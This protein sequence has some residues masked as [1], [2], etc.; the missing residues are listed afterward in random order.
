ML[1]TLGAH[2]RTHVIAYLALF[3]A[4]AGTAGAVPNPAMHEGDPAGGDLTGTYPD[5][6]IAAGAVTSAKIADGA[7]TTG[8]LANG[9][10]STAKIADGAVT[11]AKFGA[12]PTVR[13]SRCCDLSE[14]P[15]DGTP[16]VLAFDAEDF[17]VGG[18][19]TTSTNTSRL[20]ASVD[21]V[22]QVSANVSWPH[23][24]GIGAGIREITLIVNGLG[25]QARAFDDQPASG[26]PTSQT[27]SMLVELNAGDYLELEARQTSGIS[28]EISSVYP[29][30]FAMT[31]VAPG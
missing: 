24:G 13:V 25:F 16:T 9:A 14:I 17:D 6:A 8:K 31:W 22:Y 27:I 12:I 3:F 15:G 11:T 26:S 18:L 1:S 23:D 28:L 29:A 20:T 19:H 4:L 30:R 7:V 5:P 21:G 10:V 2:M